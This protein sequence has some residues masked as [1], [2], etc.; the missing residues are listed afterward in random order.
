MVQC[1]LE[2]ISTEENTKQVGV[3]ATLWTPE[4]KRREI[5]AE[6]LLVYSYLAGYEKLQVNLGCEKTKGFGNVQLDDPE[7][8]RKTTLG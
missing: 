7:T 6:I 3:A 5:T 2:I 8:N 4:Y 1:W